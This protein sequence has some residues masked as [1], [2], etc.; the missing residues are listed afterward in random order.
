MIRILFWQRS[1]NAVNI[2]QSV[3]QRRAGYIA[4]MLQINAMV[5]E[6]RRILSG[7]R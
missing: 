6:K 7:G 2:L 3:M 4:T 5:E 1:D